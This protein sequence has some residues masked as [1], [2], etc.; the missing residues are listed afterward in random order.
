[1]SQSECVFAVFA[2]LCNAYHLS[3]IVLL[4]RTRR[5]YLVAALFLIYINAGICGACIYFGIVS[6]FYMWLAAVVAM[7]YYIFGR[8]ISRVFLIAVLLEGNTH[9]VTQHDTTRE[10]CGAD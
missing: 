2:L 6:E 8:H 1:G 10:C 7:A 9:Y 3:L 4:Y 5:L